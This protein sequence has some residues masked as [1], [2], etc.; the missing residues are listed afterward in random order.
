MPAAAQQEKEILVRQGI[1]S[2]MIVPM[3]SGNKTHG[4]LGIDI[5][6][7]YRNWQNEDYQWLASLANIISLCL[8]LLESEKEAQIEREYFR[9]LY[10]HMPIA[11]IRFKILY[12]Q[13]HQLVDYRFIDL[14]PAFEKLTGKPIQEYLNRKGSECISTIPFDTQL[15][16]LKKIFEEGGYTQMTYQNKA[17]TVYFRV[18]LY[19]ASADEVIC[20]F[21]DI[22]ETFKAHKALDHSEKHFGISSQIYP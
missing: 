7:R 11:Y 4:Y 2:L 13:N 22:T 5:V 14:N 12:D 6:D 8:K 9:D 3:A 18:I 20:F 15:S 19:A 10:I 16:H 21:S 17:E 1:K